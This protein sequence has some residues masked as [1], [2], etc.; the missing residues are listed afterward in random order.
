MGGQIN[1]A[2]DSLPVKVEPSLPKV[3]TTRKKSSL[4]QPLGEMSPHLYVAIAVIGFVALLGI[5][6]LI[7]SFGWVDPT[8][9]PSLQQLA[10]GGIRL[11]GELGFA[12]DIGM[13]VYRVLAG[14]L[15]AAVIAVPLG[16]L[17]GTFKP[18]EALLEPIVSFIRYMPASAFVPLFILWIGI[19]EMEK[20]T[21]IFVGSFFSLVL[22]VAVQARSI[23]RELLEAA[24]TLGTSRKRILWRV[25]LPAALPS[26]YDDLRMVLG[27]AWTYIIVAEMVAA[28]QGI[29]HM[30]LQSQRM[31][32]TE[33]IIFGIVIIGL[34]GL[35]SDLGLRQLGKRLFAWRR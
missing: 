5:W 3:V 31:L 6:E 17:I 12:L 30:I 1:R 29:G 7:T 4:W 21:V 26:I 11:F 13:T 33:N 23:Q 9:L 24:Y 18:V 16:L 10:M 20:I 22:M 34:I 27:W 15:I 28:D 8:F 35:V 2:E 32:N 19:G 25:I 14:F